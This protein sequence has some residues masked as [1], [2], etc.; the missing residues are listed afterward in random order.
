MEIFVGSHAILRSLSLIYIPYIILSFV[1]K[2]N[3]IVISLL[4]C[5]IANSN[6][7]II[8][9]ITVCYVSLHLGELRR[10]F[11]VDPQE[12]NFPCVESLDLEAE[13]K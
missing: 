5:Y 1:C 6:E 3:S 7:I 13:I 9:R 8:H 12:A 4:G 2:Y 11:S 10:D